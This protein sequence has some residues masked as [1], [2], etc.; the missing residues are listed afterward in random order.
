MI[1]S[2]IMMPEVD[3]YALLKLVRESKNVKKHDVPFIF[4][5]ALGQK[6]NV[7]KGVNLSANDYLVKPIEFDLLIAKVKEKTSNFIRN[8]LSEKNNIDNI[9]NQVGELLPKDILRFTDFISQITDI[10]KSEPYG[11]FP[12]RK[13]I[14]DLEKIK[15]SAAK[16]RSVVTNSLSS[17]YLDRSLNVSEEVISITSFIEDFIA[18]LS[19][20]FR[21]K[22]SFNPQSP[23]DFKDK[24]KIDKTVLQESFRKIFAG[25]FKTNSKANL[26]VSLMM[27]HTDQ[28]I[29]IFYLRSE[30]DEKFDLSRNIDESIVSKILASQNC[31]FSII[32]SKDNTSM[33]VIPKFRVLDN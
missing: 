32:Q 31:D 24:V 14:E 10:L 1:I 8:K 13:Y 16:I 12:H 5:T 4:L 17:D 6:D 19:D 22:I 27:D 18:S 21:V 11:P 29:I 9:K 33:I 2:D 28:I 20:K 25:L 23:V 26:E 3:G 15:V 30:N 7:I